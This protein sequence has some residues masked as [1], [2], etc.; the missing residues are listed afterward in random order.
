MKKSVK[1]NR[2]AI[3]VLG[4]HRSGTSALMRVVNL[5]GVDLGSNLML[6]DPNVN[7][8]GYWEHGD[9]NQLN[10]KLLKDLN[11]SW[12]D[13]RFLPD[14]WWDS[15][16][17]QQY[18]MEIFSILERDLAK[19]RFWGVKDPRICRF[20]PVWHLLLEQ[21][22]SK[23]YFLIIVRNPLEVVSSLSKRDGFSKGKSCLLWLK[24]LMESEKGTRNL[25]RV[26][27]TY[28][29][30]LSDWKGLMSRVQISFRFKWP[31]ALKKA[32]P[33]IEAFLEDTLRHNRI[34]D[35]FL[36]E[37]KSLSKW[38]RNAYLAVTDTIGEGDS[39]LIKTLDT[40]ESELKEIENLYEPALTDIWEKY[41]ANNAM[42]QE[43]NNHLDDI[44]NRLEG[45]S[46]DRGHFLSSIDHLQTGVKERDERIQELN[47]E[48]AGMRDELSA[49]QG[50]VAERGAE[51]N[52]LQTD[53]KEKD[54]QIHQLYADVEKLGEVVDSLKTQLENYSFDLEAI[55]DSTS[56]KFTAPLRWISMNAKKLKRKVKT[57]RYLFNRQYR[58]IRKS[59]LFDT[60]YYVKQNQ[61]I[62]ESN[63]IPLMHYIKFGAKEGR[64]PN[65][66]FDISYY[67]G[68]NPD[69][70]E[71]GINPL[72]HYLAS[73]AAEGRDPH[74]LFMYKPLIYVLM[75]TY[76]IEA[77]FLRRVIDS[78]VH[79]VYSNWELCIC[80]DGSTN[81]ETVNT[82][83]KYAE[84]NRKIH[85]NIFPQ[86][87]GISA[88][89][90]AAFARPLKN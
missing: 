14:G 55:I 36:I 56:W 86:N 82:L 30:L 19:S 50:T 27:V 64:N 9:I 79:Q 57:A 47:T 89:T 60:G 80:D 26:F 6:A 3:I 2:R 45:F 32:E 90:N 87:H 41:R 78:V 59:G 13:V 88:A 28:E 72:V 23:P 1:R 73:G 81:P 12:D 24:H 8:K 74:P 75:P 65:L 11:S 25:D 53:I 67:L 15:D 70:T 68:K 29:E 5:C 40:I 17:A 46:Q 18:K 37:D 63:V 16:T 22:G 61:D 76:N 48:L 51:V 7:P 85:I 34:T 69:V 52:H 43:R 49:S 54:E 77:R 10:E 71:S 21:T 35:S 20:L 39:R 31:V 62:K 42:L 44:S 4:M 38:I 84:M 58:L 33:E 83:L 66:L